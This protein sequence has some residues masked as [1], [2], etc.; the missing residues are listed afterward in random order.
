MKSIAGELIVDSGALWRSAVWTARWAVLGFGLAVGFALTAQESDAPASNT[1]TNVVVP[2]E[3]LARINEMVQSDDVAQPEDM[4]A[5][6]DQPAPNAGPQTNGPPRS[7]ARSDSPNRFLNPGR[8]QTDDRRSR[9]KR[10]NRSRSG[11]PGGS[12]S[13]ND[14]SRGGDRTPSNT[15]SGTN[16]ALP[17]LDYANFRIIVDRNIFD[18]NRIPRR[19]GD[20]VI[21]QAPRSVDSLT[22]VGTMS[23]ENGTFAFFDG[24][25]YDY[26][27][28]LKL[29][30][31][32][33]GYKVADIMPNSVKLA[34]GTNE[35]ELKVGMQMRR[36]EDGPW[37]VAGQS[38]PYAL[39]SNSTSTNSVAA[40]ASSGSDAASGGAE[41]DIIKKLKQQR[42][43]E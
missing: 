3:V 4:P 23:Y 7:E 16:N 39:K 12:G 43:Q 37:L 26:K 8:P 35:L 41:N 29:T 38:R 19:I 14:Y 30:D 36:E 20:R 32:I 21:R 33:A 5:P 2:A 40:T 1:E 42:E 31:V 17:K 34:A 13:A 10:S 9:G 24:S 6:D 28:A 15:S 27:K 25:S 11:Q 22:L 18:P